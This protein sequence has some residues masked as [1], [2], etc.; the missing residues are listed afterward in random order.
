MVHRLNPFGC[1]PTVEP[2]EP[3]LHLAYSAGV[4]QVG[5]LEDTGPAKCQRAHPRLVVALSNKPRE[6]SV[7]IL[8]F[9]RACQVERINKS[10]RMLELKG[11]GSRPSKHG[12]MH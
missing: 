4:S 7:C 12:P 5:K 3:C 2:G 10:D 8:N 11:S 9:V 6:E 1:Q